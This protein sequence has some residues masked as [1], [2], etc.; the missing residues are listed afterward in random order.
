MLTPVGAGV[1]TAQEEDLHHAGESSI[2]FYDVA[3][4]ETHGTGNLQIDTAKHT[5]VFNGKDFTPDAMIELKAK[6]E[7]GS[8]TVFA[9]GHATPSGNLH[10][11][12]TWEAGAALPGAVATSYTA[13]KGFFLTNYGWFVARLACYYSIDGGVTWHES[14]QSKDIA[15]RNVRGSNLS[16]L[17][18]PDGALVK[19]HAVVV[20]GKD[21]TGSEVFQ[22]VIPPPPPPGSHPI[23]TWENYIIEGVTWNPELIYDGSSM[24]SP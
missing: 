8:G 2:Y 22:F 16:D 13:I 18:V 12:G 19:I 7:D 3:A 6:A 14:A 21:R 5:F 4:T 20:G 15:M 11:A 10:I 24:S 17:G 9:T 23:S 1:V